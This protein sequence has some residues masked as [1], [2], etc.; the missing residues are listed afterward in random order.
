MK[1]DVVENKRT[2]QLFIVLLE[3]QHVQQLIQ[4][5]IHFVVQHKIPIVHPTKLLPAQKINVIIRVIAHLD[6]HVKMVNL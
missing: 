1:I 6:L 2:Q 3:A 4:E 5:N